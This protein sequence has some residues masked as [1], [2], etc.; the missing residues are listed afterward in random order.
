M[1]LDE[2]RKFTKEKVN[3]PDELLPRILDAV[4]SVRKRKINS[5][6]QDTIFG[7]ELQSALTLT[8]GVFEYSVPRLTNIIRSGI[9]FVSRN[10]L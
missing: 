8:V 3:T 9:T 1:V 4:A 10:L 6:E 5:D 2:V 7:H